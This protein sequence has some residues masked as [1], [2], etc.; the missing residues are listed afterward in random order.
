MDRFRRIII[1]IPGVSGLAALGLL[2]VST[3]GYAQEWLYHAAAKFQPVYN[4]NPTMLQGAKNNTF[5]LTGGVDVA[6]QKAS[7]ATEV[8]LRGILEGTAYLSYDYS[9][10]DDWFTALALGTRHK[11]TERSQLT[12]DA[13]YVNDT[14]QEN[15]TAVVDNPIDIDQGI[16]TFNVRRNWLDVAPAWNYALTERSGLDLRYDFLGVTYGSN[17]E[18]A[19]LENFLYNNAAARVYYRLR[20]NTTVSGSLQGFNYSSYDSDSTFNGGSLLAGIE[21]RFS[22]TLFAE[23]AAGGYATHFDIVGTEES[24]Q[25]GQFSARLVNRSERTQ[26]RA[27]VSRNLLPSGS[28][29][30]READQVLLAASYSITPQLAVSLRTRFLQTTNIGVGNPNKK[31]YIFVEPNI[32]WQLSERLDLRAG[33]VYRYQDYQSANDIAD[34]NE[35]FIALIYNWPGGLDRQSTATPSMFGFVSPVVSGAMPIFRP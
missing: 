18:E 4:D 21:H 6:A 1:G 3:H 34:S 28:G 5:A 22:K 7:E 13:L 29:Q 9:I 14:T 31:D 16:S 35:V 32:T 33:Y 25:G 27:Q 26:W 10:P 19:D 24:A 30:M 11:A 12:L 23:L 8:N 15:V 17:K 20:E 2:A